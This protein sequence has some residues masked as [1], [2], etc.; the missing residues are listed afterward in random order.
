MTHGVDGDPT[1][2]LR[3]TALRGS[4]PDGRLWADGPTGNPFRLT[5][6][7]LATTRVL[8]VFFARSERVAGVGLR[9]AQAEGGQL[10]GP[11][12]GTAVPTMAIA[13]ISSAGSPV[14][15]S[16]K[17]FLSFISQLCKNPKIL[18]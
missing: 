7:L 13:G 14:G 1:R 18:N 16:N 12:G 10:Q 15:S 6:V 4:S 5:A 8:G 9:T 17:S 11:Q 3:S 2:P